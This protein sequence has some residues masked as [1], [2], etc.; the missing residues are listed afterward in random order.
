MMGGRIWLESEAGRGAT[1]H[2]TAS[3]ASDESDAAS[4]GGA[5]A[6]RRTSGARDSQLRILVVDDVGVNRL[7]AARLLEKQG[8][9]VKA[10]SNGREALAAIERDTFDVMLLDI[11]MPEMDGFEITRVLRAAETN[12]GRHFPIVATTAHAMAGDRERCLQAGMDGYLSKPIDVAQMG[13][14]I[15]RVLTATSR[16]SVVR[17]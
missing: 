2:F 3:V 6:A 7:V 1:F 14:E 4:S 17:D 11:E 8:H 9:F 10:V 16:A 5:P 12:T 13:Q 15:A